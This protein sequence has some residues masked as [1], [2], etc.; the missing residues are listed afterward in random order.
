MNHAPQMVSRD[1]SASFTTLRCLKE[2][3]RLII[4][5]FNLMRKPE[6]RNKPGGNLSEMMEFNAAIGN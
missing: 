2:A 5:Y 4:G 6:D 3:D 1:S